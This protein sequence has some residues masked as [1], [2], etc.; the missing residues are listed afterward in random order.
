MVCTDY[1]KKPLKSKRLK[2]ID[3]KG[4]LYATFDGTRIWKLDNIA[5]GLLKMCDG[6]KTYEQ[7]IGE[8]AVRANLAKEDVRVAVTPI[9]DELTSLRFIEW[10]E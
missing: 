4:T 2:I 3:Y 8:A 9:F 5:H 6:K 10:L 1:Q 7:I